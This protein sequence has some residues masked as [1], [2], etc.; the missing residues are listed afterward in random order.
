ADSE[1]SRHHLD[2][3]DGL[4]RAPLCRPRGLRHQDQRH[5]PL[6]NFSP[7]EYPA[8]VKRLAVAG[9]SLGADG[10]WDFSIG[11]T[12]GILARTMPFILMRMVIYFVITLAF[13][14]ASGTGAG[15]G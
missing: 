1:G 6:L 4:A 5:R 12:I 15:I 7:A 13:I 2:P 8:S 11:K 3:P 9:F 10:M 14:L